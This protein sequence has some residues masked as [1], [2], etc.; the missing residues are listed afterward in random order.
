[1]A[2]SEPELPA[3]SLER[4]VARSERLAAVWPLENPRDWAWAG[5]GG[6]GV[7][8]CIIDSGVDPSHPR[9]G[10][11]ASSFGVADAAGELQVAVDRAGDLFGHGTACAGIIRSLAPE[12]NVHSLRVLGGELTGNGDVLARGLRWAI[13]ERFDLINLSLSTTK[14][15][16]AAQ[17]REL[18][19]LAYFRN[20]SIVASAHNMPVES[21]PWRFSSVLSVGSHDG[22]DPYEYYVNPS[23]PVEF[24]APG[25]DLELAWSEGTTIVA[26]GNSFAAPHITGI[27]A[28]ILAK[29]PD[30]RPYELKAVL[31]AA[32][33]NEL[34]I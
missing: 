25:V 27:A 29:H 1:M 4:D 19:D 26:T 12:C 28:L 15:Q 13:E 6:A 33:S 2:E 24:V 7:D 31:R 16:I 21:Y 23:P 14:H 3:W 30:L 18:A 9:V 32:S 5:S 11:V 8:V 22:D 10:T 34:R 20:V 17:L